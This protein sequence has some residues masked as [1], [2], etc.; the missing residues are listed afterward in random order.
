MRSPLP[1]VPPTAVPR[2]LSIPFDPRQLRGISPSDRRTVLVR[3]TRL[4]LEAAG[5]AVKE[6]GD[7]E[8]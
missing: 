4:L 2:Q 5:I 7:D 8:R 3:L 1:L 6:S